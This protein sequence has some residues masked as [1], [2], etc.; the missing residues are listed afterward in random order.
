MR[1]LYLPQMTYQIEQSIPKFSDKLYAY[2]YIIKLT[3]QILLSPLSPFQRNL[4]KT[5]NIDFKF[6][7]KEHF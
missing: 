7:S 6:R 5:L 1:M 3:R 2:Y 4:K